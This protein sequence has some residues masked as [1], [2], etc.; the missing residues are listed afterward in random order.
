MRADQLRPGPEDVAGGLTG[1]KWDMVNAAN[2]ALSLFMSAAAFHT[3]GI[4]HAPILLVMANM[5]DMEPP[6]NLP[7]MRGVHVVLGNFHSADGSP[8]RA[9]A[10]RQAWLQKEA[11]DVQILE[12][13]LTQSTLPNV[14]MNWLSA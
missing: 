13:S 2:R 4:S 11:A 1:E 6:T 5:G 10:W 12:P 7:S 14:L 9:Q 8:T 3:A